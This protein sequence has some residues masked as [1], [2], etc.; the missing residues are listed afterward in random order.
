MQWRKR[1]HRFRLCRKPSATRGE[2]SVTN[3][4]LHSSPAQKTAMTAFFER[5]LDCARLRFSLRPAPAALRSK[6]QFPR[7][8]FII[9]A[10]QNR[11]FGLAHPICRIPATSA[12]EV[13][14]FNNMRALNYRATRAEPSI[15]Q[16]IATVS[17]ARFSRAEYLLAQAE[18][19]FCACALHL[20]IPRLTEGS[21]TQ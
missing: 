18:S 3:M 15:S 5:F 16:K 12:G 17:S 13:A 8:Q 7:K 19:H 2:I 4:P 20:P 21:E 14:R 11:Y 10:F 9:S 6:G 1:A